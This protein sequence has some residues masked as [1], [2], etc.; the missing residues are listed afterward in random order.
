VLVVPLPVKAKFINACHYKYQVHKAHRASN[1]THHQIVTLLNVTL[2][3]GTPF[4]GSPFFLMPVP[5]L[6]IERVSTELPIVLSG[7]RRAPFSSQTRV[8]GQQV[9]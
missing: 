8:L 3:I 6:G 5:I 1:I 2:E 4:V 7:F 9:Q